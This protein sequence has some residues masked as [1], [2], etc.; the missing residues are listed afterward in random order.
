[1][2]NLL[3]ACLACLLGIVIIWPENADLCAS[4]AALL[5]HFEAL[6][7]KVSIT[8]MDALRSALNQQADSKSTHKVWIW[9]VR[10]T[11]TLN[12]QN[13]ELK[14]SGLSKYNAISLFLYE[15]K[16]DIIMSNY[17]KG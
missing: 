15:Q 11:A 13:T 5:P 17:M 8:H 12:R 4:L 3:L 7:C 16:H 9:V 10:E 1:M 14:C 6:L 2:W